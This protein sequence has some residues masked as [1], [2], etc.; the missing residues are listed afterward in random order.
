VAGQILKHARALAVLVRPQFLHDV[1][2]AIARAGESRIDVW[3]AHLD[4]VRSDTFAWRNL[5]A[6]DV[7]DDYCPVR[8][9]TQLS[10]VRITDPYPFPKSECSFQP[11]YRRSYVRVNENRSDGG[12]WRRTIRQHCRNTTERSRDSPLAGGPSFRAH[13]GWAAL[14]WSS[15][16]STNPRSSSVAA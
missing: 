5:I 12:G 11:R 7:S 13:T 15:G 10:A 4:E 14:S 1:S 3:H 9:D 8:S 16:E 2:T 6:T